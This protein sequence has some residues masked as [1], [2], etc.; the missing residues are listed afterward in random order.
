MTILSLTSS[1]SPW[2]PELLA[3][4]RLW[5]ATLNSTAKG[6]ISNDFYLLGSAQKVLIDLFS[7]LQTPAWWI[8]VQNAEWDF[9]FSSLVVWFW[10][11][12]FAALAAMCRSIIYRIKRTETESSKLFA[13][14]HLNSKFCSLEVNGEQLIKQVWSSMHRAKCGEKEDH[15]AIGGIHGEEDGSKNP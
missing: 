1:A 11:W 8:G 9:K 6:K 12:C 7:H 5:H 13:F 4:S 14:L 3:S 15:L 10:K 2:V